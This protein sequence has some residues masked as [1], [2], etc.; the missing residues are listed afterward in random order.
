MVVEVSGARVSSAITG[1]FVGDVDGLPADLG[2]LNGEAN[3]GVV[4]S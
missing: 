1:V 2:I 4:I 3:Q